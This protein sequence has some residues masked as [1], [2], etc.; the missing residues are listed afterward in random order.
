MHSVAEADER[1]VYDAIASES[2]LAAALTVA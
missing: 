2:L 1:A